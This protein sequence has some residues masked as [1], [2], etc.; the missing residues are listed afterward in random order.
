M[1]ITFDELINLALD[2]MLTYKGLNKT[3]VNFDFEG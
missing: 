1:P 3:S 2:R